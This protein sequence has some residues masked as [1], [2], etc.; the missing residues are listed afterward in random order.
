MF[1]A[2]RVWRKAEQLLLGEPEDG[3]RVREVA[4]VAEGVLHIG[5]VRLA[6][7]EVVDHALDPA[8]VRVVGVRVGAGVFLSKWAFGDVGAVPLT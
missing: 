3:S 2:P 8:L 4:E 7:G 6:L 5:A 1:C